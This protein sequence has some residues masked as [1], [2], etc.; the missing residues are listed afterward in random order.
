MHRL[1]GRVLGIST[2]IGGKH[3]FVLDEEFNNI[4]GY[5]TT[6]FPNQTYKLEILTPTSRATGTNYSDFVTG[7]ERS[8]I[9]SGLFQMNS[10]FVNTATGYD[11]EKTLTEINCNKV[12]NA[13]DYNLH[14]GAIWTAQT[15]GGGFGVN[16]ETELY[17]IIGISEIEPFKYNINAMEYNPSKYLYVES[18]FSFTDAP[19]LSPIASKEASYPSGLALYETADL[20]L[21]YDISGAVDTQNSETSYWRI[22]IKSGNDFISNDLQTQYANVQGFTVDVPKEDFFLNSLQV[23]SDNSVASGEHVPTGNNQTYY[24]RIYKY[25]VAKISRINWA[26]NGQQLCLPHQFNNFHKILEKIFISGL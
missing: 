22:Y 9:Q 12:F 26:K 13:T 4:S 25:D 3:K 6:N 14:T 16:T 19:V 2:G 24:F 23:P 7:Y 5:F 8:K 11:P 21:N 17:R 20:Y 18:G 1:G 10:S 15:T